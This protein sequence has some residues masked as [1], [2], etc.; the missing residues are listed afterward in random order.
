MSEAESFGVAQKVFFPP[1]NPN[2]S[3]PLQFTLPFLVLPALGPFAER[4]PGIPTL[5]LIA[6]AGLYLLGGIVYV[7]DRPRLWPRVFSAHELFH[8]LILGGSGAYTLLVLH[9]LA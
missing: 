3:I 6:A 4:L 5:L 9:Y 1:A 2:A 8:V 7:T